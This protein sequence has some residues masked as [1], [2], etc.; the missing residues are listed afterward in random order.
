MLLI[1]N[2][3]ACSLLKNENCIIHRAILRLGH[4]LHAKTLGAKQGFYG[5]THTH[6]DN[7][8]RKESIGNGKQS[9]CG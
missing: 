9:R 2:V 8:K 6:N 5:Y 7:L 1:L 4:H 3:L